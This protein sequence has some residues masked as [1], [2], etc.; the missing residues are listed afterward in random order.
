[1]CVLLVLKSV[2]AVVLYSD[3][4]SYTL[5]SVGRWMI[6]LV[7]HSVPKQPSSDHTIFCLADRALDYLLS[8]DGFDLAAIFRTGKKVRAAAADVALYF[9]THGCSCLWVSMC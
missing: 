8:I 5:S 9:V 7:H 1:M 6:R 3:T 2:E 4:A